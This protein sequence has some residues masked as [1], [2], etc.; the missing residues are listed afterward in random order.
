[1]FL[2]D[3]TAKTKKTQRS[4]FLHSTT[5]L[6]IVMRPVWSFKTTTQTRFHIQGQTRRW[7][8]DVR[9]AIEH[10]PGR[11]V[12]MVKP[13]AVNRLRPVGL[14]ERP[15]CQLMRR[16]LCCP[17]HPEACCSGVVCG[18][19]WSCGDSGAD[20]APGSARPRPGFP[21]L[22]PLLA[23]AGDVGDPCGH[24]QVTPRAGS[25]LLSMW[26]MQTSTQRLNVSFQIRAFRRA[27]SKWTNTWTISFE[28]IPT[29]QQPAMKTCKYVV[30]ISQP[31]L[32]DRLTQC[33]SR[34]TPIKTTCKP[35]SEPWSEA[36]VVVLPHWFVALVWTALVLVAFPTLEVSNTSD[37]S[38]VKFMKFCYI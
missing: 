17:C 31:S 2:L 32:Q 8:R 16:L 26:T 25:G 29:K 35:C 3:N 9:K 7:R 36:S 27:S 6:L 1:M 24:R 10:S 34:L 21:Y 37:D 12:Q 38:M 19:S 14:R 33:H 22:P 11:M 23:P 4:Q 30:N 18:G 5:T 13:V 20:G 28:N 15:V